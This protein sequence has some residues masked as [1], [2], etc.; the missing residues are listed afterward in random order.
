M[1][2]DS[3]G[4]AFVSVPV[5]IC[6]VF[7]FSALCCS[8][9][10]ENDGHDKCVN[11]IP[12]EERHLAINAQETTAGSVRE[13][14]ASGSFYPA[15]SG[16]LRRMVRRLLQ[17]ARE[18]PARPRIAG[19]TL[20]LLVPHAGYVFSGKTAA[21]GFVTLEDSGYERVVIVG[22]PHRVSL[23]GAS[24]YCG[25]SFST[26]LGTVP[27]DTEFTN[28]LVSSSDLII[29]D[30]SSHRGEH[31]LEV[32]LPFLQEVLGTFSIVPILVRGDQEVVD[33]VARALLRT[34]LQVP[35][36]TGETLWV[37]STDLSHYPEK[38]ASMS[39]DAAI[40][41]AFCSLDCDSLLS[42]DRELM[43]Q[44]TKNLVCTMCGLEAAYVGIRVA[45]AHSA[46]RAVVLHRSVSSDALVEGVDET[47]VVGY[48][49][50]S[51]T[52]GEE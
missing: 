28:A 37:I 7:I 16:K 17:E 14:A 31:S 24:V 25:K 27:V 42:V 21:Y 43:Q 32:Q 29:C 46:E 52:G 44:G 39:C 40:L 3:N 35:G 49:A 13:P 12:D 22:P 23:K 34:S 45:R 2:G 6:A 33:A 36:G 15:D 38:S 19:R 47:R 30:E 51:V 26:P 11:K 9:Q 1:R 18:D 50:V 10:K 41:E 20:V 48:A 8:R 4:A 5:L